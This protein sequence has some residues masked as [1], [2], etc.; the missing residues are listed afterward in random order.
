MQIP[1]LPDQASS[2]AASVDYL[3]WYLSAVSFI[4]TALI[5][6]AVFFF[7]IKYRRRSEDEIPAP[8]HGSIKLEIAWSVL[9]FL[10]MLTFFWW[11]AQIYFANASPP[12]DAMDVY[13]V[14]KQW[15]WKIQYP[16][17]QREINE[18]HVPVGRPVK[19]TTASE[20]VI[21]SFFVPAFRVK[22]DVVPGRYN[23]LAAVLGQH[24][25]LPR[26]AANLQGGVPTDVTVSI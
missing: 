11:G 24:V 23:T 7:A 21:H 1:L 25:S 15:M 19:I 12:A 2:T 26:S 8:I 14:G 18:L 4:M 22:Q 17:G 5:F 10:V 13:A 6:G 16:E 20:D 3:Y 9:P